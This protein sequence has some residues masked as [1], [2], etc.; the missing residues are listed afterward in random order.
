LNSRVPSVNLDFKVFNS[1][2]LLLLARLIDLT[3]SPQNEANVPKSDFEKRA[4][5]AMH[6]GKAYYEE[7]V[8]R[9]NDRRLLVATAVPAV[10]RKCAKCHG[11]KQ[12]DLLGFLHY[13]LPMK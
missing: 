6:L 3:G 12:G 10:L 11:V 1:D 7:V 8:G 4:A 5:E 9:G 2:F 13:D